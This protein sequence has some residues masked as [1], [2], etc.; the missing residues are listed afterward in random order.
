G[1]PGGRSVHPLDME[2]HLSLIRNPGAPEQRPPNRPIRVI[3]VDPEAFLLKFPE[4]DTAPGAPLSR[5]EE[6][7]TLGRALFDRSAK[8]NPERR[9]ESVFGPLHLGTE[10]DL[11]G[12][13]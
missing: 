8:T 2:Y 4:L 11:A 13:R 12:R 3:G 7:K 10:T 6:L 1:P 5:A 9:A